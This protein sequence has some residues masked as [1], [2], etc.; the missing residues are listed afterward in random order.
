MRSLSILLLLFLQSL[1]LAQE[2]ATQ[3]SGNQEARTVHIPFVCN[4]GEVHTYDVTETQYKNGE[5]TS[6]KT[7]R[8]SLE[9]LSVNDEK[10]VATMKLVA[11]VDDAT[12][13]QVESDPVAKQ[14]KALW[15]SL[16]FEVVLAR[17]GVF[18]EF[19][20]MEEIEAALAQNRELVLEILNKMK[21]ALMKMG[22]DPAEFDRLVAMIMKTQGSTGA[23]LQK[24]QTPLQLILEFVNTDHEIG[25]PEI[26]Q[27]EVDMGNASGLPATETYRV[28]EM[29]TDSNF[30]VVQFQRIVEGQEAG[31]KFV[32]AMDAAVQELAPDHKPRTSFPK[33]TVLS[34]SSI[35]G[36]MNLTS[37]WPQSVLW[38]NKLNDLENDQ[39]QLRRKTEIQRVDPN[40]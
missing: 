9:I 38:L 15:D 12:L 2:K 31:E 37:G 20:N 29:D 27:T 21:P 40:K 22:K 7:D 28:L 24:V 5:E 32:Q 11:Q 4:E 6:V 23:A 18:S 33:V 39:L 35:K 25:K 13:K 10:I 1:A 3:E 36:K 8:L 19:Q 30:A 17:R 14:V 16:V 26:S 34:D